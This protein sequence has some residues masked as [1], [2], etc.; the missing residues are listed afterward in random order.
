[1]QYPPSHKAYQGLE[2]LAVSIVPHVNDEGGETT[3]EDGVPK[4]WLPSNGSIDIVHLG[5]SKVQDQTSNDTDD[6]E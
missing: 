6:N 4:E 3:G 5:L 2:E 1:M